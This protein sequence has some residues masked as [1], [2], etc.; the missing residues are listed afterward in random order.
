MTNT[1][2]INGTRFYV[3]HYRFIDNFY[4][5]EDKFLQDIKLDSFGKITVAWTTDISSA[6]FFRGIPE[7]EVV[8]ICKGKLPKEH[9]N[10]VSVKNLNMNLA[11][12]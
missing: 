12:I 6:K 5:E 2:A 10:N 4:N 11:S 9:R 3:I 1:G 8:N 7:D